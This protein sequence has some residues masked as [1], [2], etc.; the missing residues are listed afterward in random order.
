MKELGRRLAKQ[1][2]LPTFEPVD[3]SLNMLMAEGGWRAAGCELLVVLMLLLGR[4]G[5]GGGQM[6]WQGL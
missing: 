6:G 5:G 3:L 2:G 4:A 1:E